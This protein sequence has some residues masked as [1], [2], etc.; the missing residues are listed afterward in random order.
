MLAVDPT[1]AM[2]SNALHLQHP[3]TQSAINAKQCRIPQ[4]DWHGARPG[5]LCRVHR[6]SR[7][8]RT[9]FHL[10]VRDPGA[11]GMAI[12]VN[13]LNGMIAGTRAAGVNIIWPM[14]K[15]WTSAAVRTP[16]L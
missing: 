9:K 4:A 8:S 14:V 5:R 12:L 2:M 3:A 15:S 16:F 13:N 6:V 7:S 1:W 10:R 11:P